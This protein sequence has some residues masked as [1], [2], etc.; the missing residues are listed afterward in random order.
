MYIATT[1]DCRRQREMK[2][3]IQRNFS[4]MKSLVED[5]ASQVY[6]YRNIYQI[7]EQE[8]MRQI[9]IEQ[10]IRALKTFLPPNYCP[11]PN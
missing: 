3:V 5:T 10:T 9:E 6:A 2:N 11:S 4:E 7:Q 8:K 1:P